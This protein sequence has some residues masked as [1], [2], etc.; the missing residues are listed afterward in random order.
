MEEHVVLVER[1]G[2]VEVK[3]ECEMDREGKAR[4][5]HGDRPCRRGFA[6]FDTSNVRFSTAAKW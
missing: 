1:T 3:R 5:Q 6:H 2:G 4:Q